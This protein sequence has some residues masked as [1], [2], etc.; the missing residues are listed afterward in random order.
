MRAMSVAL[1]N[2]N[3]D[4]DVQVWSVGPHVI[5]SFTASFCNSS[6]NFLRQKGIKISF[7]KVHYQWVVE[8]MQYINYYAFFSLPKESS[9]RLVLK[10]QEFEGC[11]VGIFR[12]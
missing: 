5:N 7:S 11:E 4:N 3:N 9:S 2:L 6:E 8:N 1:S 12:Y 10:A